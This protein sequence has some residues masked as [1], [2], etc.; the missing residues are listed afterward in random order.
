MRELDRISIAYPFKT[1]VSCSCLAIEGQTTSSTTEPAPQNFD[2]FGPLD[3]AC[4]LVLVFPRVGHAL[5]FLRRII[6]ERLDARSN[7]VWAVAGKRSLNLVAKR[8]GV[9][10]RARAVET[11]S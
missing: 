1:L 3:V 4:E 8:R 9:F 5:A 11:A 7:K 10:D 2:A 6:V